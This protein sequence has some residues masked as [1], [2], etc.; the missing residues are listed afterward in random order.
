MYSAVSDIFDLYHDD[1]SSE[2]ESPDSS[3]STNPISADSLYSHNTDELDM[4][5]RLSS[6]TRATS[7]ALSPPMHSKIFSSPLLGSSPPPVPLRHLGLSSPGPRLDTSSLEKPFENIPTTA[8]NSSTRSPEAYSINA[9]LYTQDLQAAPL[10]PPRSSLRPSSQGGTSVKAVSSNHSLHRSPTS[11]SAN[12]HPL[13]NVDK[14]SPSIPGPGKQKPLVDVQAGVQ[15]K[16][17]FFDMLAEALASGDRS[18]SLR[19][20]NSGAMRGSG[21]VSAPM[22]PTRARTFSVEKKEGFVGVVGKA[23]SLKRMAKKSGTGEA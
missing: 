16:S 10:I 12:L 6:S 18:S 13:R 20:L 11:K 2:D 22:T 3:I 1:L 5:P 15:E 8:L 14:P 9:S 21:S 4:D 7:S 17:R 19:D 23:I